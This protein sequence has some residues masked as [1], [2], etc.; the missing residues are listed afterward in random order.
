[1][2]AVLTAVAGRVT[3]VTQS[4]VSGAPLE[5]PTG[6]KPGYLGSLAVPST[7]SSIQARQEAEARATADPSETPAALAATAEPDDD[8]SAQPAFITYTIQPGDTVSSIAAS[9]GIDMNYILWNNAELGADPDSLIVGNNLLVPSVNGL[10]YHVTLGDTL[11]DIASVYQIDVQNITGFVS[12]SVSTPDSVIEGMV[13]VL[14]GA[15]PPPAPIPAAID[16][17]VAGDP[18]PVAVPA[19]NPLP[20]SSTGYIWPYYSSVSSYFGE[21]RGGGYHKGVDL[22]GFGN[23]GAPVAAA[24]DGTVVLATWDDWGLGYHVIVAHA[25]GSRTV[26]AHLSEIYVAQGQYVSQGETVGALGDTGYATGTHLH[27]ELWIG[28]TPV[29]PLAYLP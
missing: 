6:A 15:V 1:M 5:T 25:D 21:A 26:Y 8:S 2:A 29:D 13:L 14:P 19:G 27:F 16:V 3:G 10:V 4:V 18:D 7:V 17:I 22:D 9:F 11:S 23:W 12:N 24:A 28:G 20:P